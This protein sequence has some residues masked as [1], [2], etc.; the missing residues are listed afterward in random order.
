MFFFRRGRTI[1]VLN[2]VDNFLN[3][4][5]KTINE[6]KK[7]QGGSFVVVVFVFVFVLFLG[8][9]GQGCSFSGKGEQQLS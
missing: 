8:R 5:G 6:T 9:L 4:L 3:K 2:A 7:E 1:A